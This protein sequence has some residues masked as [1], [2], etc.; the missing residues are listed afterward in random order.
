[1]ASELN[2]TQNDVTGSVL[3]SL[4][5]TSQVAP[6][7]WLDPRMGMTYM[8]AAQTPQRDL[9][10]IN[11]LQNTPVF[12]GRQGSQPQL[13]SNLADI[14]RGVAPVAAV[15]DAFGEL[16]HLWRP[17]A[18]QIASVNVAVDKARTAAMS[19]SCDGN[20]PIPAKP[21][22]AHSMLAQRTMPLRSMRN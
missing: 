8:V 19:S 13:L 21:S 4:S 10:S 9:L 2:L 20:F 11:D 16:V 17:D 18:A 6:N 12:S 7:F 1:M 5:S 14:Q 3:V 15:V 22:V